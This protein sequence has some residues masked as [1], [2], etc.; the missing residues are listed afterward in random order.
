MS[1]VTKR[2][3]YLSLVAMLI[4]GSLLGTCGVAA[5]DTLLPRV[6]GAPPR[7]ALA[8]SGGG[9]R[10]IAHVGVLKNYAVHLPTKT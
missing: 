1:Q 6:P 10:G 5:E 4:I 9:A 8:L 7:I 3:P 2:L